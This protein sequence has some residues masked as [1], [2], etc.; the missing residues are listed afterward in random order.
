MVLSRLD[1]IRDAFSVVGGLS[2]AEESREE[3]GVV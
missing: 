3:E 2:A 1:I